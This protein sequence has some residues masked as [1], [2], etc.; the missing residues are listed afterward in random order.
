MKKGMGTRKK[1]ESEED[2]MTDTR[3]GLVSNKHASGREHGLLTTSWA[4]GLFWSAVPMTQR[5]CV[6]IAGV[7]V[8]EVR[9]DCKGSQSFNFSRSAQEHGEYAC[10]ILRTLKKN[11][12]LALSICSINYDMMVRMKNITN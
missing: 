8:S 10:I 1:G 11:I 6:L 2:Y 4:E 9:S 5:A 12:L 3:R 7:E